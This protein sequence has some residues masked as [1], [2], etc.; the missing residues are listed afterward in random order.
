MP[1]VWSAQEKPV[2]E[3]IY[4]LMH[5][6]KNFANK[7]IKLYEREQKKAKGLDEYELDSYCWDMLRS[8]DEDKN[9]KAIENTFAYYKKFNQRNPFRLREI[10]NQWNGIS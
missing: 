9:E 4:K 5:S 7:V 2:V 8:C 1:Q 10:Y 6:S 3:E